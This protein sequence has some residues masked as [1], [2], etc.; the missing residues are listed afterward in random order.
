MFFFMLDRKKIISESLHEIQ[1]K[2]IICLQFEPCSSQED[3]E[4]C[5]IENFILIQF[6]SP[7]S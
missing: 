3:K 5:Y 1:S 2:F 4:L 6:D 7:I